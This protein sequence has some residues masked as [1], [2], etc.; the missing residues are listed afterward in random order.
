MYTFVS[1]TVIAAVLFS[2]AASVFAK[3]RSLRIAAFSLSLALLAVGISCLIAAV[4]LSGRIAS[5]P[6]LEAEFRAWAA[7]A[8]GAWARLCGTFSAVIGGVLLIAALIRHPFVKIRTLSA[9]IVSVLILLGGGVYAVT[10]R[11]ATA[12][13]VTPVYLFSIACACLVPI[14]VYYDTAIALFWKSRKKS[15]AK[16]R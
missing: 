1:V 12:D 9:V 15:T 13:L 7:D 8:Y 10:V 16:K 3:K 6:T 11:N 14:G 5:D 2:C 4:V